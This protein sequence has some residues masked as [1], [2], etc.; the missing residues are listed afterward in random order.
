MVSS[1]DSTL[2][3]FNLSDQI[4]YANPSFH[5]SL[6]WFIPPEVPPEVHPAEGAKEGNGNNGIAAKGNVTNGMEASQMEPIAKEVKGTNGIEASRLLDGRFSGEVQEVN[7]NVTPSRQGSRMGYL[8]HECQEPNTPDPLKAMRRCEEEENILNDKNID[9]VST[10][11]LPSDSTLP[12]PSRMTSQL[13]CSMEKSLSNVVAHHFLD[14]HP[15]DGS[16]SFQHLIAS[17]SSSSSSTPDV[18]ASTSSFIKRV[19]LKTGNKLHS[20]PLRDKD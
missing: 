17:S 3:E 4:F 15:N 10:D 6:A 9:L 8:S 16:H 12:S 2:K 7:R 1:V 11:S 5:L 13:I 19:M 14:D 20:F 18:V